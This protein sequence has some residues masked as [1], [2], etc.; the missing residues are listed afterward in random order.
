MATIEPIQKT[1]YRLKICVNLCRIS[2]YHD[3]IT[4]LFLL[5][6][7]NQFIKI[8]KGLTLTIQY[9]Y[10]QKSNFTDEY[11]ILFVPAVPNDFDQLYQKLKVDNN[12]RVLGYKIQDNKVTYL[13]QNTRL[14]NYYYTFVWQIS[15][16]AFIQSHPEIHQHI[17]TLVDCWLIKDKKY[18]YYGIGGE[19]GIY[20]KDNI[21]KFETSLCL[22]NSEAIYNDYICNMNDNRTMLVNYD[23]MELN[24]Y[25]TAKYKILVVNISR[26]GLKDLAKQIIELDFD[27]IIYIGCSYKAIEQDSNILIKKYKIN[28]SQKLNQHPENNN[29]DLSQIIEFI[30]K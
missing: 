5:K 18:T 23:N 12:L 25:M 13:T 14:P 1:N 22:T 24:V 4:N 8:I 2:E 29:G 19:S 30:P 26:N 11:G 9:A 17:H 16:D 20:Y 7:I 28:R 15:I 21:D 27:Q 6:Q 3:A 10:F